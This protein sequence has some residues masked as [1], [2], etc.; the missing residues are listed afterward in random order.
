MSSRLS[1]L[2]SSILAGIRRYGT[3]SRNGTS[4]YAFEG[5][6]YVSFF[7]LLFLSLIVDGFGNSLFMDDG[8]VP[9]LLS[10]PLLGFVSRSDPLYVQTS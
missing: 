4:V 9:S 10:L 1:A 7:L 8:N 3:T 2:A 6:C 5:F